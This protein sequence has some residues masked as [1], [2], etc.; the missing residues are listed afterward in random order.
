MPATSDQTALQR[1]ATWVG[2]RTLRQRPKVVGET[3]SGDP[4]FEV[5]SVRLVLRDEAAHFS[6]L[7]QCSKCGRE[8]PGA[9]VMGPADLDRPAHSLIC[10]D[11]VR[12]SV[13]AG[14]RQPERRA[15]N[16][17]PPAP[18]PPPPATER[19]APEGPQPVDDVRLAAV[20]VQLE[21]AVSR[22]AELAELGRD[23]STESR[24][25]E[26][27][28][29]GLADIRAEVM[30]AS[31][32]GGAARASPT[33]DE[34]RKNADVLAH[35]VRAQQG[36]LAALSAALDETRAAMERQAEWNQAQAGA[37]AEVDR[38]LDEGV[39]KAR[40]E[41]TALEQRVRADVTAL[42]DLVQALRADLEASL[43]APVR[44]GLPMVVEAIQELARARGVTGNVEGLVTK[45]R[46]AEARMEALA[47][48][49]EDGSDRLRALELRMQNAIDRLTGALQ[50][51]RRDLTVAGEAGIRLDTGVGHTVTGGSTPGELL[52]GLERQL[53]E[54]EGR[55][56]QLT[57]TPAQGGAGSADGE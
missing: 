14:P 44:T 51:H 16:A 40:D 22:L 48:A 11:C 18:P 39:E 24:L 31:E 17:E 28:L 8:V 1:R 12:A 23:E 30:A 29:R 13:D 50:T 42:T 54:A 19:S 36:Q 37:Q 6:R 7:T 55:L 47:S 3:R 9:P 35:V 27:L 33:D 26:A 4:V 10:K 49:I 15:A 56:A 53:Q 5:R 38:R 20:E 41:V 46:D 45:T 32:G 25:H 21:A 34:A 52:D 2:L 43:G 57:A